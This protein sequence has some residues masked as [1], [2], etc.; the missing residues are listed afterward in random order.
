MHHDVELRRATSRLALEQVDHAAGRGDDDLDAVVQ[1]ADLL[2]ERGAA[3]DGGDAHAGVLAERR[4]H[5]VDLHGE[6]T[7]RD[8][9]ERGRGGPAR[10]CGV[11]SAGAGRPKASVLPEPVLALPHTSR[12][13]SASAIVSAWI[14]KGSVMPAVFSASTRSGDRPRASNVV[15]M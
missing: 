1:A 2:F 5:V 15:L 13:A 8:E 14:G 12:P 4:E 9:H 10:A 3:V 7:G 6:L 11:R